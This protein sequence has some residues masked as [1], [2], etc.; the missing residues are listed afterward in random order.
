MSKLPL[1]YC[2]N[3]DGLFILKNDRVDNGFILTIGFKNNNMK[4]QFTYFMKLF[5]RRFSFVPNL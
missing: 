3:F 1:T 5:L 4:K 2:K